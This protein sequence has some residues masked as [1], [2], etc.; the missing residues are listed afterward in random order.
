[1]LEEPETVHAALDRIGK[2]YERAMGEVYEITRGVNEGGS[3]IQ[4]LNT[5]APGFHAQMQCDMSVM[6]SNPLFRKFILPELQSQCRFLEYPLYHFDGIE[7]LRHLDD[8][9]SVP[10]LRVIQWTQVDGQAPVTEYIPALQ[11]IQAAGKNLLLNAVKPQQIRPLMENLS[12]KGL[13][14]VTDA[15]T[16]E[17]AD[18]MIEE[19][20]RLTHD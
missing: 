9:L 12:S 1:M 14:L 3:A 20:A 8:I 17:E 7:Q 19:V 16:R 15:A 2:S 4:W 5:W 11:K 18:S 6:I 13:L 10:E